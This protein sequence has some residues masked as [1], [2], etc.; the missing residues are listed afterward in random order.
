MSKNITAEEFLE[1]HSS[2][3]PGTNF[4]MM[5]CE[6]AREYA[7]LLAAEKIREFASV[8]HWSYGDEKTAESFITTHLK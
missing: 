1:T 6:D 8:Y 3:L 2:P 4:K 7:K 5:S